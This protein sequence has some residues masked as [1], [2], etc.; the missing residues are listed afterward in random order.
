MNHDEYGP[1]KNICPTEYGQEGKV[2]RNG[3]ATA[4]PARN[5][6]ETDERRRQ[7]RQDGEDVGA[8]TMKLKRNEVRSQ[9]G[10]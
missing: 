8:E 3:D 1:S 6:F 2:S 10:A 5:M 4:E 7:E 9:T